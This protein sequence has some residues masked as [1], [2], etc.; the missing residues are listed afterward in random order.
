MLDTYIRPYINPPLE[1]TAKILARSRVTANQLTVFGFMLWLGAFACLAFNLYIP[2]LTLILLNLLIDGLDGPLSRLTSPNG[3][4]LGAFLDSVADFIFYGGIV[5][6][7]ALGRPET[8]LHAAFLIF[9]FM[10]TASSFLT[11]AILATKSGLN[12]ERQGKKSFYY[13]SGLTEGTETTFFFVLICLFPVYFSLMAIIFG[14]MCWLTT[15]GRIWQA[16]K[17]FS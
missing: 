8:S 9:S 5:F 10:G 11:Y 4:D 7:F 1:K 6:F 2:A 14:I 17:T 3:S 12:H 16:I 15:A 13:L